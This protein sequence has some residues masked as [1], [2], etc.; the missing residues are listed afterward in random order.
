MVQ[1]PINVEAQRI[2]NILD[3]TYSKI[4]RPLCH[5]CVLIDCVTCRELG[6]VGAADARFVH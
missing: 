3:D 5:R 2:K 1:K 6:G 4:D